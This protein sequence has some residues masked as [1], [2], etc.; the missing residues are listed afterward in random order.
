M[1]AYSLLKAA[2]V[3][4]TG[5]LVILFSIN[6]VQHRKLEKQVLNAIILLPLVLRML[7]IK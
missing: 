3:A 7:L 6:L 5:L 1:I 2:Y 4:I